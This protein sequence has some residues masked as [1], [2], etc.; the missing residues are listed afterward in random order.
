MWLFRGVLVAS[1]LLPTIN[2]AL[3]LFPSLCFHAASKTSVLSGTANFF[4]GFIVR[5]KMQQALDASGPKIRQAMLGYDG[6]SVHKRG[7]WE[8]RN[9]QSSAV[10]RFRSLVV[11][12]SPTACPGTH[13]AWQADFYAAAGG[14]GRMR[15]PPPFP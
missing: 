5:L 12:R 8:S 11:I 9:K 7:T 3:S 6:R 13:G 4:P 15:A 1:Q 10:C 14:R 2:H